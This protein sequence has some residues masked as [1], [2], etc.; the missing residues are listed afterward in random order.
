MHAHPIS[1][2]PVKI[3]RN[4]MYYRNRAARMGRLEFIFADERSW[5][6]FFDSLVHLHTMRWRSRGESGVLADQRVLEWH[7][8]AI[9]LLQQ[10]GILRF[11]ELRLSGEVLG[12]AYSLIDPAA[13]PFR[14]QYVYLIAHSMEYAKLRPGTLLLAELIEHA[15]HEGIDMVDMLRGEENYK[16]IWHVE[17]VPTYGFTMP[18]SIGEWRLSA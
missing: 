6:G 9:P 12:V 4:A 3:R 8:E 11:C 2:L 10:R 17:S 7:R 16:R 5:P 18:G 13:R 1:N 14:T 15:A